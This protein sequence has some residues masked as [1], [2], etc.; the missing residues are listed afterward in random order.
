[1][2]QINNQRKIDILLNQRKFILMVQNIRLNERL[3][4]TLRS[5]HDCGQIALDKSGNYA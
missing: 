1:M 4:L 2:N 3:Q 5:Y